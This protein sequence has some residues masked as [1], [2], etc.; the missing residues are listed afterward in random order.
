MRVLNKDNLKKFFTSEY[1]LVGLITVIALFV[2]LLHINKPFGLWY[3]EA[4]TYFYSA[5]SFP[6]G[7][8]KNMVRY[9]YHMPLY[10]M[11]VHL[12]AK[13]FG[14]GDIALRLSSTFWGVLTIPVAY[15]LGKVFKSKKLGYLLALVFCLSPL[16]IYYSQELRFYSM[17]VFLATASLTLF[18]M[19]LKKPSI[20]YFALLGITNLLMLYIYT[21]GIVFV[22]TELLLMFIDYFMNKKE[23]LRTLILYS[24]LFFIGIVPYIILVLIIV[25]AYDTV[26]VT[27]FMWFSFHLNWTSIG[28]IMND[29]FSPSLLGITF[30][31]GELFKSFFKDNHSY[32]MFFWYMIPTVCFVAGLISALRKINKYFLFLSIILVAFLLSEVYLC[33]ARDFVLVTRYT[34]I[35]VPIALLLC[36]Y[37]LLEIKN[38][39]LRRIFIILIFTSFILNILNYK[40]AVTYSLRYDGYRPIS[41]ELKKLNL[42]K[43]DFVLFPL[44]SEL[45][46][47][48][49]S[50][51]HFV[52]IDMNGILYLD[53]TEKEELK[54]FNEYF[55][56]MTNRRNY[57]G[58]FTP[59]LLSEVPTPELTASVNNE[60]K[61]MAVGSRF[62]LVDSRYDLKSMYEIRKEIIQSQG[63]KAFFRE[64]FYNFFYSKM[65]SD[66]TYILDRNPALEKVNYL[67]VNDFNRGKFHI[68]RRYTIYKKIKN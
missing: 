18:L 58:Q 36:S 16:F 20:K 1:F 8:L 24:A 67:S 38:N 22:L 12:W 40:S 29:W 31:Y 46:A 2:R 33:V 44:K 48:Y 14:N 62:V 54:A 52:D 5:K 50:N 53:K 61:K 30:V 32:L 60:V 11:Y 21:L 25:Q 27:P 64:W 39:T 26:S 41:M 9:D 4:L 47:K 56:L 68:T 23:H 49:Y 15:L 57:Q 43:N 34:I 7:I 17:L 66:V 45:L 19:L 6:L 13:I 10:Y 28:I 35:V 65:I 3:D 51:A 59:F 55:I 63:D 42:N 37:G